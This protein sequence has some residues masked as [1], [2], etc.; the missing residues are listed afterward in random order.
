MIGRK[1][2]PAALKARVQHTLI[3]KKSSAKPN[4]PASASP[5]S[6]ATGAKKADPAIPEK[7][8][9]SDQDLLSEV[10]QA[11]SSSTPA[12]SPV[13]SMCPSPRSPSPKSTS[14]APR[15]KQPQSTDTEINLPQPWKQSLPKEDHDFKGPFQ[16]RHQYR[17]A[18]VG[19]RLCDKTVVLPI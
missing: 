15:F 12:Q 7:F 9:T 11:E 19:P 3:A 10:D 18:R 8:D 14:S 16:S 1:L 2:S 17:K 4:I 13:Q 5:R 6:S